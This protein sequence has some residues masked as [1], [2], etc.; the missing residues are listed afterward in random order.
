MFKSISSH[1]LS[2]L[3][4]DLSENSKL[5]VRTFLQISSENASKE[6]T[7][8]FFS[9]FDNFD[10]YILTISEDPPFELYRVAPNKSI[11]SQPSVGPLVGKA[12][13]Q[14]GHGVG[15]K[16]MLEYSYLEI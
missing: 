16:N 6:T 10:L 1:Q 15:T 4:I 3:D 12:S 9:P 8:T 7:P 2:Q 11:V 5:R 13:L 14:M